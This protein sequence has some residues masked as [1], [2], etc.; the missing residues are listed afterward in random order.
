MIKQI[1]CVYDDLIYRISTNPF[2]SDSENE[3]DDVLS[4]KRTPVPTPRKPL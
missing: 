3:A 1:K 4:A 2:G